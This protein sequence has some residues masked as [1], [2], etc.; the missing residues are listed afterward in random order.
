MNAAFDGNQLSRE[1]F[2]AIAS[3]DAEVDALMFKANSARAEAKILAKY[4][5]K[6]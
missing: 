6:P 1:W 4:G 3:S 2:D 5:M